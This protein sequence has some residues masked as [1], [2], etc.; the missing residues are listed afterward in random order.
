MSAQLASSKELTGS[1]TP[2]PKDGA[3]T[4]GEPAGNKTIDELWEIIR[5]VENSLRLFR[6]L[7]LAV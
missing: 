1:L 4:D 7:W 3:A 5:Y 6:L 2:P